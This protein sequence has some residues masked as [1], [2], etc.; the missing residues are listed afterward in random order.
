MIRCCTRRWGVAAVAVALLAGGCSAQ[1]DEDAA[2]L[3]IMVSFSPL[4]F[5]AEYIAGDEAEVVNLTPAGADPHSMELSPSK[6][7]DLQ[8]AD[9]V[10][11]L[12]GFQPATDDAVDLLDDV[13]TVDTAEAAVADIDGASAPPDVDLDPHFWL[14]PMRLAYAGHQV[15]EALAEVEPGRATDFDDRAGELEQELS[16]LDREYADRLAPCAGDTVVTA[17]EAFG[18]LAARYGL[19]QVGISGVDPETEPSPARL[20]EVTAVIDEA[21]VETLFFEVN[22]SQEV[23]GSLADDLGIRTDTLDP[24]ERP[25]DADYLT[26]MRANLEA[27]TDGL[28]CD[29]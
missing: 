6:F 21:E 24:M 14:D 5:V 22:A 13:P 12:S 10:V 27:L 25:A 29:G 16:E 18:Y 20:R 8:E 17:H 7:G 9:L 11:Y 2:G 15:A 23:A 26:V 28:I 4:A 3:T 1:A 19:E